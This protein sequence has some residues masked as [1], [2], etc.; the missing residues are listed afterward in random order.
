MKQFHKFLIEA[1]ILFTLTVTSMCLISI[2]RIEQHMVSAEAEFAAEELASAQHYDEQRERIRAYL[3]A[4]GG[5]HP[6]L[7]AAAC[8]A[9]SAPELLAAICLVESTANPYCRPGDKGQSIGGWQ[10]QPR[11]WGRVSSEAWRQAQQA[12]WVYL[13]L[14]MRN[15]GDQIAALREYNAGDRW[16][17]KTKSAK[18][19]STV[20]AHVAAM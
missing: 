20:L 4:H 16:R 15:N 2:Q 1:T 12:E 10:V 3:A 6:D 11:H 5:K 9:T 14:L 18:Y 7:V 17:E 8:M 19:A 13:T